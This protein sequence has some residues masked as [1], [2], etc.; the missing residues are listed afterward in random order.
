[1]VAINYFGCGQVGSGI[2][3]DVWD[4][5]CWEMPFSGQQITLS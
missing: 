5:T 4:E 2:G 3:G 1:M